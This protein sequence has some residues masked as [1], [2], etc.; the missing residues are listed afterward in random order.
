MAIS[1]STKV[2]VLPRRITS[3]DHGDF[4]CLNCLH[5]FGTENKRESH[6]NVH[7]NKN[8]RNAV[9]PSEDTKIF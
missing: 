4:C 8:F 2:S 6:K 1:C 5:S 3:K 9:M 7:K